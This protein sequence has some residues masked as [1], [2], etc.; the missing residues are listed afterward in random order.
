M[1]SPRIV[2]RPREDASAEGEIHALAAVYRDVLL[3]RGEQ[4][5][6]TNNSTAD[7]AKNGPQKTEREKT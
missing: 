4:H 1:N 6:L 2:Y 3:R 7:K 5:D